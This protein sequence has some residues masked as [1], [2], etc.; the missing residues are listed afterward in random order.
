MLFS[1]RDKR[2][3]RD[4]LNPGMSRDCAKYR[5]WKGSRA[6]DMEDLL[7]ASLRILL[8]DDTLPIH[9]VRIYLPT[10]TLGLQV[11]L[12]GIMANLRLCTNNCSLLRHRRKA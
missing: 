9:R 10:L 5:V 3:G 1:E 2:L 7:D 12:E 4:N 8:L 6:A 11:V